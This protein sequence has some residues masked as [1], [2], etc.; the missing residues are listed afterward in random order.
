[1]GESLRQG[2][3]VIAIKILR[4]AIIRILVGLKPPHLGTSAPGHR[5]APVQELFSCPQKT[6][7]IRFVHYVITPIGQRRK[8][9]LLSW[10]GGGGSVSI[11][12]YTE[13]LKHNK[14]CP[15]LVGPQEPKQTLPPTPILFIWEPCPRPLPYI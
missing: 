9:A 7:F 12:V 2:E 10:R 8:K 6:S 13:S 3:G 1:M 4:E 5:T 14:I 11:S 15:M